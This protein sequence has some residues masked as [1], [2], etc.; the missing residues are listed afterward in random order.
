MLT[1][2]NKPQKGM[3]KVCQTEWLTKRQDLRKWD[4]ERIRCGDW[5]Y[6]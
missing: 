5:Q 4:G 6:F 1:C 3:Q 2:E